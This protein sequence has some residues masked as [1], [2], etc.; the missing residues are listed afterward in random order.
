M[1]E[2][3]GHERVDDEQPA[4]TFDGEDLDLASGLMFALD[5]CLSDVEVGEVLELS[6]TNPALA[7]ELPAWCRGTGHDLIASEPD[8]PRTRFR[9]RRGPHG[10]LMFKDR[11]DWGVTPAF[12]HDGFD[13]RDW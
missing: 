2:H 13:T 1:K 5:V 11:P 3:G 6:S 7:H 9:I 4:A 12:R 10:A 8:G